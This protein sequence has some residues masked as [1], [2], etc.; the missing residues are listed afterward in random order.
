[1]PKFA[2][3]LSWLFPELPFLRRFDA[4][5]NAGFRA[6]EF[7]FPYEH[8][9]EEIKEALVKNQLI[10]IL[11]NAPPGDFERGERGLACLP[12]RERDFQNSVRKAIEYADALNV[13]RIHVMAGISTGIEPA[14]AHRTILENIRFA[15]DAVSEFDIQL[16]LEPINNRD[17]PGY[18]LNTVEQTA[19]ILSELGSTNLRLQLD[20]YHAQVMGG[21]LTRRT[22]RHFPLIGHIQI[23]G[24][25]DRGEPDRGEVH[26]PHLLHLVDQLG[27]NG[28]IGCEYKPT[29]NT[30]SGLAW[31]KPWDSNAGLG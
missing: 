27:Y 5:K 4:A 13:R 24:V 9:P 14:A 28:W 18:Y 12:G 30:V 26:F 6:V 2:A 21:D 22:E 17:I 25:P 29:G 3:N 7:L 11:F 23:A 20:W 10:P 15:L 1:M 8:R 31:L 19:D 16:L